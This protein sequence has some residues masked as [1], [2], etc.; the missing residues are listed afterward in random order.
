MCWNRSLVE[1]AETAGRLVAAAGVAAALPVLVAIVYAVAD[2]WVAFG[3]DAYITTLA[4]D[5]FTDRSPLV[6]QRSSG[7]SGVLDETAYSPGPL[8]FWLLA[9]PVRLGGQ[10]L[11]AVVAGLVNVA[12]IMG[13]VALA[14]RRGGRPL[15]LATAIAIPLMLLSLPG[16]TYSDVWNS[17]APLLPLAVLVFLAWSVACGELRLLPLTVLVASFAMHS[18]LT[19]VAPATGLAAAAVACAVLTRRF[20][21]P[22]DRTA[23]RRWVLAAVVVGLVCWSAPLLDQ[24]I[25]RPGNLVT[26]ARSATA[27]QTTVGVGSGWRAVVHS[28]GVRP[29]WLDRPQGVLERIG[30]ITVWPSPLAIVT[31]AVVLGGLAVVTLH[32]WRRRRAD[33]FAAGVLGLT[34]CAAIFSATSSTPT[35]ATQTLDYVLRWTS[36][37][38]MAV[39]LLLGFAA[40]VLVAPTPAG[41]ALHEHAA[42]RP[43][44]LALA[45]AAG[46][47]AAALMGAGVAVARNPPRQEPYEPMRTI[48]ERLQAELPADRPTFVTSGGGRSGFE[49]AYQFEVGVV[50][51]L[52]RSGREVV[53]TEAVADRLTA[54]YAEGPYRQE[55]RINVDA[56]R[57]PGRV[58]ARIRFRDPLVEV[59]A[60]RTVSVTMRPATRLR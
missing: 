53:T 13:V 9:L 7:A 11:P 54:P 40:A 2:G 43:R 5:V 23:T 22:A 19:F 17:S 48:I 59:D 50:Y 46:L 38:G 52:R 51:W 57:A 20:R 24:V 15:M 58:L 41:R 31:A 32:G 16:E 28:V 42:R 21:P 37:A 34:L 14:K 10:S 47:A 1:R 35:N 55:V 12:S 44:A 3:D 6:G 60:V 36:P 39:W 27:E 25:N 18:H 45:P 26:L 49:L 30:D 8:L 4:Y 56:P 33:V 29:W